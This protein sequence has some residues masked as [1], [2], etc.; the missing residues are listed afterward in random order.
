M[1]LEIRD[2]AEQSRGALIVVEVGQVL[3]DRIAEAR[4]NVRD[5]LEAG[6]PA[7]RRRDG[8]GAL[9]LLRGLGR[10]VDSRATEERRAIKR[11]DKTTDEAA[12][13][14]AAL[15]LLRPRG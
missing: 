4:L 7:T 3:E 10:A 11:R 2:W 14:R 15:A 1:T 8:L 9:S 12:R 5:I 6:P 13:S